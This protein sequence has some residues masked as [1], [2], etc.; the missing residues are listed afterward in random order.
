MSNGRRSEIPIRPPDTSMFSDVKTASTV[1]LSAGSRRNARSAVTAVFPG[2]TPRE[3]SSASE[4]VSLSVTRS[5]FPQ[6]KTDDPFVPDGPDPLRQQNDLFTEELCRE[7]Q[8]AVI[9]QTRKTG[10]VLYQ[11]AAAENKRVA[12][13]QGQLCS[14]KSFPVDG[15]H[16]E[17]LEVF[18]DRRK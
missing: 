18:K 16:P 15:S 9:K 8:P 3:R 4:P 2:R 11:P 7:D 12:A 1:F 5:T 14:D 6:T 10:R 17:S 13:K